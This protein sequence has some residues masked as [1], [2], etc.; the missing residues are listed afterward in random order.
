LGVDGVR[1][2]RIKFGSLESDSERISL[3][4]L[5]FKEYESGLEVLDAALRG[6]LERVFFWLGVFVFSLGILG[7]KT[8]RR[9][10]IEW[11]VFKERA[12]SDEYSSKARKGFLNF[13]CFSAVKNPNGSIEGKLSSALWCIGEQRAEVGGGEEGGRGDDGK[14][15]LFVLGITRDFVGLNTE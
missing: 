15:S 1:A 4:L 8:V 9:S 3:F 6:V 7:F 14:E 10:L 13:R 5:D 2:S 12:L 11:R